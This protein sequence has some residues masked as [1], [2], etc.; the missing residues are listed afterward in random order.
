M[1]L[2][3]LL[4]DIQLKSSPKMAK[5]KVIIPKISM[6]PTKPTAVVGK[7]AMT[8]SN[9]SKIPPTSSSKAVQFTAITKLEMAINNIGRNLFFMYNN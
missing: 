6:I 4:G 5:T 3:N 8:V 7:R 9:R 1:P 2:P